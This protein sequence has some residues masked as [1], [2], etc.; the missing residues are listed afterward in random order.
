MDLEALAE[1]LAPFR[2]RL[3]PRRR[4]A[5]ADPLVMPPEAGIPVT[6]D[7]RYYVVQ[8]HFENPTGVAGVT[9]NS[10]VRLYFSDTPRQYEAGTLSLDDAFAALQGQPVSED[11]TDSFTCPSECTSQIVQPSISVYASMLHA[12]LLGRRL[13]TN[14]YRNGSFVRTIE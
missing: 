8:T 13:W 11:R 14:V 2:F 7:E 12:H 3:L 10:S 5:G 9:D 4:A 1:W 6:E